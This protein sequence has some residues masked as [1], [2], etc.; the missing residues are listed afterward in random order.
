MPKLLDKTWPWAA[1]AVVAAGLAVASLFVRI[2]VGPSGDP[3]PLGSVEDVQAFADRSDTNL[4]FILVDTLRAERLGMYDYERDTSPRLDE[5]ASSGVVFRRHLAQSSW[6]KCSMASLWTSL[7]PARSG[8]TRYDHIIPDAARMPAEVLKDAGF[9]TV[10]IFRNGWVAATFGFDQGFDTYM[11]PVAV[12]PPPQVR[13]ENP[14][15]SGA[16]T[17]QDVIETALEYLRVNGDERWFLYMHMMDVHEY[18]YDEESAIFGGGYSSIYDNSIRWTDGLLGIFLDH[19]AAEGYLENTLI[20]LASDHGEAFRERG[21]EGH[22]RRVFREST[23]VPF[24]LSFPFR[25]EP[26]IQVETR[27]RNV[28]IWP[29]LFDLLGLEP[30]EQSDGRSLVPDLVAAARGEDPPEADRLGYAHLDQHWG[31]RGR[32][33]LPTVAVADGALRYVRAEE[34]GAEVESVFDASVDPAE[35]QN[36]A[37]EDKDRLVRMRAM[38]DSYLESEPPWGEA[39]KRDIG[40]MEL[41]QLR[42]LGYAIP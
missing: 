41:N 25:L 31:Q 3:R 34:L 12:P 21:V 29:T 5:F 23:E 38:A 8:V 14:T 10:G 24:L 33:P 35:L 26:G 11:R 42:A 22:A 32:D 27:S 40:E 28:D 2:D 30:P 9:Q 18:V 7:N 16:G 36:L 37:A 15:I 17:D 13:L 6:T 4:L 39:P 1:G 19:L 20:V